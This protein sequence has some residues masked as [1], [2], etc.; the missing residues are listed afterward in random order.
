MFQKSKLTIVLSVCLLLLALVMASPAAKAEE[1]YSITE[2]ELTRLIEISMR[3]ETLN[4][5]LQSELI[6]SK[7]NLNQLM[8]ELDNYKA[9]LTG[10]EKQLLILRAESETLKMQLQNA[11]T[12]LEKTR[13]S[14]DAYRTEVERRIKSLTIQRNV[15]WVVTIIVIAATL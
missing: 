5:K 10:L 15:S 1:L 4:E 11:E 13:Q 7:K 9:E 2:S 12:L 6:A 3:L 14:L 8:S